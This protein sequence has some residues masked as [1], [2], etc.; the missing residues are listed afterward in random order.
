MA[1][2]INVSPESS[3]SGQRSSLTP[4]KYFSKKHLIVFAVVFGVLG[5]YFVW[6]SFAA[7]AAFASLEAESMTKPAGATS[8][9]DSTASG[10]KF[11]RMTAPGVSSGTQPSLK[12]AATHVSVK[13]K[14]TVCSGS[15]VEMRIKVGT[16]LNT[17][18]VKTFNVSASTWT[19]LGKFDAPLAKDS[20]PTVEIQMVSAAYSEKAGKSNNIKCQRKLDIDSIIFYT[21]VADPVPMPTVTLN[22]DPTFVAPG[23]ISTLTWSSTNA[24][25]CT[26]S[27]GWSG[28]Q[29]LISP[30]GG[31]K[32][33][34]L[35]STTKYTL[36]CSGPGGSTSKFVTVTVGSTTTTGS[37]YWGAL[38]DGNDTYDEYYPGQR[39]GG[40]YNTSIYWGDAP[41][42][43]ETWNK[44]ESNAGKTVSMLH[45]GQPPPWR[46]TTF[47]EG[48]ANLVTDRGAIPI[49]S[50]S[51]EE[52]PYADII[53]GKYDTQILAWGK[54]ARAWGKPFMLRFN[55]EMNGD[56]WTFNKAA[57]AN[58]AEFK[59]MWKHFHDIVARPIAPTDGLPAGA[60]ATNVT[61][62]WCP[63]VLYYDTTADGK[64]MIEELYPGHGYVDWT[65]IDGYNSEGGYQGFTQYFKAT[66]DKVNTIST[67]PN[68]PNP[69]PK[70]MVIGETASSEEVLGGTKAGWITNT[71]KTELPTNFPN[72]KALVWFN[73]RIYH[74]GIWKSWPIESSAAS[75]AA[76]ASGIASPYY[77][78]RIPGTS[79]TVD[80]YV[81]KFPKYTKVPTP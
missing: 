4:L 22:A 72:I 53:N 30:P 49:I 16:G 14:A 3:R 70:P 77:L 23:G 35:N 1:K 60:G 50:M 59:A 42:D 54:N 68:E 69:K 36:G 24:T 41:W 38:L 45:Y 2:K 11:L 8:E 73:W 33:S 55:W 48:T 7:T 32:T 29:P 43:Q 74:E 18:L 26:A 47:Y 66:Y 39:P 78:P 57:R 71:L 62:V 28:N 51:T 79:T 20:T 25:S 46:Q 19:D 21:Q 80:E 44:F 31:L 52:I 15:S 56:W 17:P 75:Q 5:S 37:I 34:A 40:G 13:A 58:P 61:W 10:L 81:T 9:S 63:N 64:S 67:D 65:C 12:S 27:D 76:F 6:S